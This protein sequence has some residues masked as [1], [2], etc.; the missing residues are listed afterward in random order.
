MT[1]DAVVAVIYRSEVVARRYSTASRDLVNCRRA[2][3]IPVTHSFERTDLPSNQLSRTGISYCIEMKSSNNVRATPSWP[4]SASDRP[5]ALTNIPFTLRCTQRDDAVLASFHYQDSSRRRQGRLPST[6]PAD[7][8]RRSKAAGLD[9]AVPLCSSRR[10]AALIAAA[11]TSRGPN[12][13]KNY[14]VG[15]PPA[16]GMLA[17]TNTRKKLT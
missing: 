9:A 16:S 2:D 14:D 11:L 15:L 5:T 12:Y 7:K 8:S 3:S 4:I 1:K 17:G 10:R 6:R 13:A